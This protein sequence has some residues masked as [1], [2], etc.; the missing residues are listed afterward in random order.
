MGFVGGGGGG[1]L[2]ADVVVM[3]FI[4][5][6][7]AVVVVGFLWQMVVTELYLDLAPAPQNFQY[8]CGCVCV[9]IL[10]ICFN[11]FALCPPQQY[12]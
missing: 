10:A 8:V 1:F 12:F 5:L 7:F 6:F 11:K 4:Y 2:V 3:G 9:L